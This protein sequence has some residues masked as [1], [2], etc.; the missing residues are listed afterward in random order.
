MNT[1]Y[2][3]LHWEDK[4]NDFILSS[5]WTQISLLF[6]TWFM[7][8]SVCWHCFFFA[9]NGVLSNGIIE[10]SFFWPTDVIPHHRDGQRKQK[11]HPKLFCISILIKCNHFF[12]LTA[13][14]TSF[15]LQINAKSVAS[16]CVSSSRK[17]LGFKIFKH[18]NLILTIMGFAGAHM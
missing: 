10:K 2:S 18:L 17:T 3:Q 11:N 13:S 8:L 9:V 12:Y 14:L 4:W 7:W 1:I 5:N 16:Q 15:K 6:E